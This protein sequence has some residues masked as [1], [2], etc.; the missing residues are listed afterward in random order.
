MRWLE[1]RRNAANGQS[2]GTH[3]AFKSVSLNKCFYYQ[4]DTDYSHAEQRS[5]FRGKLLQQV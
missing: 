4:C 3:P 1:C 2:S 5:I